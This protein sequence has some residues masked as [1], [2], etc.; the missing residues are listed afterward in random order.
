MLSVRGI[1]PAFDSLYSLIESSST[2]QIGVIR[3]LSLSFR[4]REPVIKGRLQEFTL[5]KD[6]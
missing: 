5:D 2:E 1:I 6:Y 3:S 4:Y